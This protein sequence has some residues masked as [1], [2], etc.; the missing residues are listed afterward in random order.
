VLSRALNCRGRF[1]LRTAR[2]SLAAFKDGQRI[3]CREAAIIG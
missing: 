3:R 2:S 1:W